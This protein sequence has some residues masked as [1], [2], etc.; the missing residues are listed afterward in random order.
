MAQNRI[1]VHILANRSGMSYA[2]VKLLLYEIMLNTPRAAS[3]ARTLAIG[4]GGS[5]MERPRTHGRS[6]NERISPTP[7][8]GRPVPASGRA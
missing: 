5:I 1:G 4:I 3:A 8:N 2:D 6:L 7:D